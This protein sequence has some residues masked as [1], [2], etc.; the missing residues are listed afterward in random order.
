M[1]LTVWNRFQTLP[2]VSKRIT[3]DSKR[4]ISW[5]FVICFVILLY[6]E[7]R[8]GPTNKNELRSHLGS[9][10]PDSYYLKAKL[11]P[12][13]AKSQTRMQPSP[14]AC[15][16]KYPSVSGA[17]GGFQSI[18]NRTKKLASL[19]V[20][21]RAFLAWGGRGFLGVKVNVGSWCFFYRLSILSQISFIWSSP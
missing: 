5:G 12:S 14:K 15:R 21:R 3:N 17:R 19:M 8:Y 11:A 6:G 20:I 9:N 10:L 13:P 7:G 1:P 16:T 4:L 18:A 2:S